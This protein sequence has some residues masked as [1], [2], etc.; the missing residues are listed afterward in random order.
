MV[1]PSELLSWGLGILGTG[2]LTGLGF[3]LRTL[4]Q[5]TSALAVLVARVDPAINN[6]GMVTAHD[7]AIR[8][9]QSDMA[10]IWGIYDAWK[11]PGSPPHV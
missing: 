10:R 1:I 5:Q 2:I 11:G 6:V 4:N 7:A 9:L 3:I 8:E